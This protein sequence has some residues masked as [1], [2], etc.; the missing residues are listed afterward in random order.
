[1]ST[2]KPFGLTNDEYW[3]NPWKNLPDFAWKRSEEGVSGVVIDLPDF[4]ALPARESV[5]LLA[6]QSG[7]IVEISRASFSG[8]AIVTAVNLDDGYLH[9]GRAM[10]R[11]GSAPPSTAPPPPADPTQL[12]DA[13]FGGKNE[14][15]D[16]VVAAL[17]PLRPAT[18][19]VTVLIRDTVSN[20]VRVQFGDPGPSYEDDEVKKF[21]EARRPTP[22]PRE[23][24]PKADPKVRYVPSP[25]ALPPP[26][27]IGIVLKADRV[28]VSSPGQLGRCWISFRLP[29]AESDVRSPDPRRE[30]PAAP[31]TAVVPI[32]LL[33]VGAESSFLPYTLALQVPSYSPVA[34]DGG[35]P[36]AAGQVE[37]DLLPVA[38]IASSPQTFFIYAFSKEVMAGPA[39][40]AV[41][42]ED[43]LRSP[44]V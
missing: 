34:E 1:M 18:Y 26:E 17:I 16:L 32:S 20:R 41:I 2:Q 23:V 9:V 25:D 15:V 10:E 37:I 5:P 13:G 19:L 22:R 29:V 38:D 8:H 39:L 36:V 35:R 30:D 12:V 7:T 44:S 43:A 11:L 3:T 24:S 40:M 14:L 28:V 6:Y 27:E 42:D 21:L 33:V 4:V 31:V